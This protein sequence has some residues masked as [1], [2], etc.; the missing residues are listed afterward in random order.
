[1]QNF[2]EI[3]FSYLLLLPASVLCYAPMKGHLRYDMKKIILFGA[4]LMGVTTPLCALLEYQFHA[5]PNLL[6]IPY[7]LLLYT[8]YHKTLYVKVSQSLM[9]FSTV[10]VWDCYANDLAILADARINPSGSPQSDNITGTAIQLSISIFLAV[11]LYFPLYRFGAELIETFGENKVWYTATAISGIF[12]LICMFLMPQK[13]ETLYVNHVFR[14]YAVLLITTFVLHLMLCVIYYF[15]ISSLIR[16]HKA[17]EQNKFYEMRESH[18]LK[19]QRYINENAKVRHDFKHTIRTLKKLADKEDYETVKAYINQYF[20]SMPENDTIAFCKNH[21]VNAVLNYYH[22]LAEKA[23][24]DLNWEIDL[25]EDVPVKSVDLCNII[26][27]ILDNAITACQEIPKEQRMIQFTITYRHH[28]SLYFVGTNSFNGK[29]K[30]FDDHYLSTHRN[31][32]GIGLTSIESIAE[33]YG[34]TALFEHK[35]NEFY[36][37][38]VLPTVK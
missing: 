17:E 24:I 23:D 13:Y 35:D 33:S 5:Q 3:S 7:C 20:E 25:P 28:A 34:G 19:Q 29:V 36:S 38:V 14:S 37:N 15:I 9:I 2:F 4:L 12:I 31:G 16:T 22:Q 8:V 21:A 6:F 32:N 10:M 30:M 18:Y 26:G 11:L 1:M 27:N